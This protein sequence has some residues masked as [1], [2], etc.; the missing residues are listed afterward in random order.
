VKKMLYRNAWVLLWIGVAVA[1]ESPI[2]ENTGKPIQIP[3][4]CTEQDM[5]WAGLSCTDRE[6]CPVYFELATAEPLGDKIFAAGNLHTDNVTLYSIL[7]GS[8]DAGKTWREVHPRIQGAGLDHIQ[9]TD[10][11]NG[12]ISGE[13]LF[14]LPADPFFLITG[15]GGKTWRQQLLFSEPH[16]GSIQQFYF[17][18]KTLGNVIVDQGEGA[19]EERYALY[20]SPDGGDSWLVNQMSNRPIPLAHAA[21]PEA[22][23]RIQADRAT[24]SFRIERR[25]SDRWFP[26]AAFAVHAGACKPVSSESKPPDETA[27]EPPPAAQGPH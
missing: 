22:G 4:Q 3:F 23:W 10:L 9:F 17:S 1:Q 16:P 19:E 25:Q 6:P 21:E 2:L 14:P 12:W 7:L 13:S 18:S 20:Q 5:Q 15:D 24:E 8:E 11:L 26:A 27:P